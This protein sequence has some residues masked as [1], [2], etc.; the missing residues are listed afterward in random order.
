MPRPDNLRIHSAHQRLWHTNPQESCPRKRPAQERTSE[1]RS[2]GPT[3]D[4]GAISP[5]H[6][7]DICGFGW[8][9]SITLIWGGF[10]VVGK[11]LPV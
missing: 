9:F 1:R 7:L 4:W 11:S 5:Y 2:A 10:P 3:W 6:T 8:A